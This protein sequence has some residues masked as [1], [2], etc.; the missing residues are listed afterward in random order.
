MALHRNEQ[1]QMSTVESTSPVQ[2]ASRITA[3]SETA[4]TT[5]LLASSLARSA[6]PV[7]DGAPP[8][9]SSTV[10]VSVLAQELVS[11]LPPPGQ[12]APSVMASQ[13]LMTMPASDTRQI[14]AALR[15]GLESSGLFYE[16]HLLQWHQGQRGLS[17]LAS[18]PQASV[19]PRADSA[20]GVDEA[21][22]PIVHAQLD[23]LDTGRMRWEG[24]LWPGMAMSWQV[25][26]YTDEHA[27][28]GPQQ[29]ACR[30]DD[31]QNVWSSTLK[32]NLPTLGEISARLTLRDEGLQLMLM[33]TTPDIADQLAQ[34]RQRLATDLGSA[35]IRLDGFDVHLN[36]SL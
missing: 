10:T 9:G 8:L 27:G 7:P 12:Q 29:G 11:L 20:C 25:H 19:A 13:P 22:V 31:Q 35:G 15:Q 3:I 26:S 28:H 5:A 36:D 33:A 2:V 6:T 17:T 30:N 21:L 16:S 24:E 1:T 34:H 18:E 32:L 23:T 14:A 4:D